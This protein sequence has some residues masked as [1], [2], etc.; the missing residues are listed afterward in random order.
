MKKKILLLIPVLII[1]AIGTYFGFES[2][3]MAKAPDPVASAEAYLSAIISDWSVDDAETKEGKALNE[4]VNQS[5][6]FEISGEA[7]I[8]GRNA[9]IPAALIQLD[10]EKLEGAIGEPMQAVLGRM[11][12]EAKL[13]DEIYEADKSYKADVLSGASS[14]ALVLCLENAGTKSRELTLQLKYKKG[15]WHLVNKE[16]IVNIFVE[17]YY[18]PDEM[19]AELCEYAAANARYIRKIYTIDENATF[20]PVPDQSKFGSTTDPAV[21]EELINT[22]EAQALINGQQLVWNKDIELIGG[23]EI[24][25]YLDESILSIVWQEEEAKAVGTFSEVFIADASQFRRKIAG[26]KYESWEFTPATGLAKETNAVLASGGD[27]YHHGRNCGIV[28]YQRQA[29]RYDMTSCDICYIDS[30]G[31]MIFSYRN[32][33]SSKDEV[34]KFIEENDI[35]FSISFGPVLID[36]GK[37]VTPDTYPWG[38]INDTYARSALGMLGDKHYLTMNIN[39]MQPHHYYL[40]TLRQAADAMIERGCIK[41][42]A[43]DGGQTATT[44]FNG[45]LINPVQFGRE[46]FLSDIIYFASAVPN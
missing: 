18:E 46:R 29:Y 31:D 23:T 40:A 34:D 37:D 4:A 28:V 16:E 38:E 21:I 1:A 19:A 17:N 44:V 41:A 45:K 10:P 2:A 22:P 35:L 8:S 24:H 33:F 43:L 7:V 32:Q 5:R 6:R 15:Q 20:A 36:D 27:L 13:A 9:E 25:Y 26:D 3:I 39:C 30:K 11:V 12:D 42:Y 14:E